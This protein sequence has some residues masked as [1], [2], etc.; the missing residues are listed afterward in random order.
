MPGGEHPLCRPGQRRMRQCSGQPPRRVPLVQP[1]HE[2]WQVGH[3]YP[4]VGRQGRE[5]GQGDAGPVR[6]GAR[7]RAPVTAPSS[8][9]V[10]TQTRADSNE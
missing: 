9:S 8:N 6:R 10:P 3:G 4:H 7:V 2:R 5:G 1:G